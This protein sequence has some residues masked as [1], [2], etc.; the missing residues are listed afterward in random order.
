M[1]LLPPNS[2]ELEQHLEKVTARVDTLPIPL[3]SLWNPKTCPVDLLPWLAWAL[4]VESWKSEWPESIKR[5]LIRNAINIKRHKG[6]VKS[7]R[8]TVNA[9][10]AAVALREN[11]QL[12]PP[13]APHGFDIRISVNAADQAITAEY[14]ND[15]QAEVARIKPARSYFTVTAGVAA[16]APIAI[17]GR[18][19]AVIFHR[20]PMSATP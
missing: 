20:L 2:S 10:G 8:D 17:H 12:S 5:S 9:F 14:I 16:S 1:T 7:A 13:G 19:R 6:T 3:R 11:W 4:G 18:A 15:I